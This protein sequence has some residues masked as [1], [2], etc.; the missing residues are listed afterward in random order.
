M[1]ILKNH[2]DDLKQPLAF[3]INLSF[4][5]GVFPEA[6]KNARVTPIFKKDNPQIP[7]N[8]RPISVL[9]VFSKLYEKCMYSRLYSFL[10]KYKILFRKQFGFRNNHSTIHA[11]ISLVELIKKHLDNN[12]FLCEIFIDPQKT[13]DTVNYDILLAKIDHYSIRGLTNS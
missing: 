4:Q 5:Q 12:Y 11:L 6:L 13:F 10:T 3:M 7:S 9:S 1:K 2:P 8:Y